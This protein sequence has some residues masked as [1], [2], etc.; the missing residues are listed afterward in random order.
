MIKAS[1]LLK[2]E[3][4]GLECEIKESSNTSQVGLKGKVVDETRNLLT[5]ETKD[6]EKKVEKKNIK[7]MFK[8][9]TEE[10]VVVDGELLIGRPE[11]RTKRALPK[12]RV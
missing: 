7:I 2:H 10:K 8:L 9:P 11:I 1:N 5:I 12:K 3:L 4:I 6:G